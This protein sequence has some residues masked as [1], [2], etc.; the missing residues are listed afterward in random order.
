MQY[1]ILE[2]IYENIMEDINPGL[3]RKFNQISREVTKELTSLLGNEKFTKIEGGLNTTYGEYEKFG[4]KQGFQA[5]FSLLRESGL[6]QEYDTHSAEGWKK[7]VLEADVKYFITKTGK[8][9]ESYEQL[10]KWN[11]SIHKAMNKTGGAVHE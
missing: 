11:E 5:A 10:M 9:P 6:M 2:D 3:A 8:M 7:F 4:F 1:K